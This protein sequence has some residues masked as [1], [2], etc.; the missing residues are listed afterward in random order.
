MDDKF[1]L[2]ISL[3]YQKSNI[4]VV[5]L[6]LFTISSIIIFSILI[7][8][9]MI[10]PK[11]IRFELVFPIYIILVILIT[12]K[13]AKGDYLIDDL[14]LSHNA[15]Y[16]DKIGKINFEEIISY[17]TRLVRGFSS[18][19]ITLR[20]GKKI[21][22]GPVNN[23]SNKADGVLCDFIELFERKIHDNLILTKS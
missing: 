17:K 4:K 23:F 9:G 19:I 2:A 13:I 5:A 18:Y 7:S 11:S 15:I 16:S 6:F 22:I 20:N 12:T 3:D 1:K 10:S 8:Q 14:F 21:A